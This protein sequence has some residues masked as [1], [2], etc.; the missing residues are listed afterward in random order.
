MIS[1]LRGTIEY[2]SLKYVVVGVGGGGVGCKVFISPVISKKVPEIGKE[3]KLYTYLYVRENALDLY[4]F[5]ERE[6]E[7]FFELLIS[8]SGIGPKAGLGILSIAS[9]SEI[10]SAIIKGD[11]APLTKVSGIGKKMAEKIIL[12]LKNKIDILPSEFST[13]TSE[14]GEVIDALIGL[15]YK[16]SEAR[17]IVRKISKDVEGVEARIKEAL[18]M[19]GR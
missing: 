4:G 10:K 3:V 19:M 1:F 18:K 7:E 16:L 5:L 9:V 12:E 15:G 2:K 14:D 17:E 8:I 13:T 11:S 6:E